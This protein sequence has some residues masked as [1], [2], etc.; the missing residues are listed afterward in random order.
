MYKAINF[1][2]NYFIKSM[3]KIGII[4]AKNSHCANI[5]RICNVQ[6]LV[7]ARVVAVW[8][9]TKLLAQTVA[10]AAQIPTIAQDWRDMAGLVDGVIIDH[11]HAK[12]HVAPAR[13]FL[14]RGVP[15]FVDKPFTFTFREGKSLCALARRTK[16]PLTSFSV[17][18]LEPSFQ[19]FKKLCRKAGRLANVNFSGPAD[20]QDKD[21]GVFFYGI[22]QVDAMVEL[23]GGDVDL[24]RVLSHGNGGVAMITYKDGPI[25]TLNLLNNGF[26]EFH[27]SAVGETKVVSCLHNYDSARYLRGARLFTTMF[28]TGREPFPHERFLAPIAIL[29]AINK[30]WKLGKPVTVTSMAL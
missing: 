24:V 29:E 8:G 19:H 16:T 10:K 23:L 22:H 21:G 30:S 25:V 1:H 11:R 2:T 7:P 27:W 4:G 20:L 15:C 13:F 14:E 5:A 17:I 6:K 26:G 28:R 12:F 9:E 18:P 3:L